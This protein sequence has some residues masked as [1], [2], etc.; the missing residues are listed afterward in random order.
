MS[1]ISAANCWPDWPKG[2]RAHRLELRFLD[3]PS[4]FYDVKSRFLWKM[5]RK[6]NQRPWILKFLSFIVFVAAMLQI[7]SKAQAS[8]S[9]FLNYAQL[10]ELTPPVRAA[11]IERVRAMVVAL[12][13]EEHKEGLIFEGSPE[14]TALYHSVLRSFLSEAT[15]ADVRAPD[16]CLYAGWFVPRGRNN[17]CERPAT[18][19]DKNGRTDANKIQCNPEIFGSGVCVIPSP[20]AVKDCA[21]PGTTRY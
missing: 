8:D 2:G 18:C 10:T 1:H 21:R 6:R 20:H 19:A 16:Q 7:A 3:G 17:R 14:S 11:Y 4:S 12:E 13:A 15:A 9:L 5:K